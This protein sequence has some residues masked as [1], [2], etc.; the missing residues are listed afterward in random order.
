M[1]IIIVQPWPKGAGPA[2]ADLQT[3]LP[4]LGPPIT[5][6]EKNVNL[7]KGDS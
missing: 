4:K 3:D 1:P 5:D 6:T 7:Q 2:V